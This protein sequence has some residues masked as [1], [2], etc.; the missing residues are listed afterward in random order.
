MKKIINKN[1]MNYELTL[2]RN[3]IAVINRNYIDNGYCTIDLSND[4]NIEFVLCLGCYPD[5]YASIVYDDEFDNNSNID[6]DDDFHCPI[7]DNYIKEI[8]PLNAIKHFG[9][10]TVDKY[11]NK[12]ELKFLFNLFRFIYWNN[13]SLYVKGYD[14][15]EYPEIKEFIFDKVGYVPIK[16]LKKISEHFVINKILPNE[17]L[18]YW[19]QFTDCLGWIYKN[20]LDYS[21]SSDNGLYLPLSDIKEIREKV[22]FG[23]MEHEHSL[24]MINYNFY[25]PLGY[26]FTLDGKF[27]K[28][29]YYDEALNG[30]VSDKINLIYLYGNESQSIYNYISEWSNEHNGDW[31]RNNE[32]ILMEDNEYYHQDCLYWDEDEGDW[33]FESDK[34]NNTYIH[35]Y[36]SSDRNLRSPKKFQ[37]GTKFQVGLEVEVQ[38]DYDRD[39]A[40]EF[41]VDNYSNNER[42]FILE[43]DGS[44]SDGFEMVTSPFIFDGELP[45]WLS[46]S[47]DYLE[48]DTDR[49]F[50]NAGGHI[51]I[52]RNS[53]INRESIQLFTYL[54]NAYDSYISFISGRDIVSPRYAESQ[55]GCFLSVLDVHT[56]DNNWSSRYV[57]VNRQ[58]S[59]TIEIRIFK[60]CTSKE[61]IIKRLSLLKHMVEYCNSFVK[62]NADLLE[63]TSVIDGI[64]WYDFSG[65][66]SQQIKDFNNEYYED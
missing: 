64:S 27:S 7:T 28:Y 3:T 23:Y 32:Y 15:K 21:D 37:K 10:N 30:Y 43:E 1:G 25:N 55:N 46:K 65:L 6:L 52:D 12:K 19:Y 36:K 18:N 57:Y 44:I 5:N 9:G 50:N 49:N 20:K 2:T 14:I 61:I 47:L 29:I 24:Y 35:S 22:N 42:N 60:G 33:I 17:K 8:H 48:E 51:H 38:F 31:T 59:A 56:T 53:F 4:M 34:N 45:E 41:L 58:N 54:F 39:D 62:N 63:K 11:F 13:M 40:A 16:E 66:D 26:L